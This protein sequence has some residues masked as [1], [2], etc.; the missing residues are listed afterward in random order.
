M[1]KYPVTSAVS[2]TKVDAIA[3]PTNPDHCQLH[4]ELSTGEILYV[5]LSA[6]M[7]RQLRDR[8][9]EALTGE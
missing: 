7:L 2:P 9:S 3:D 8:I 5:Q 6:A 4:F 1:A